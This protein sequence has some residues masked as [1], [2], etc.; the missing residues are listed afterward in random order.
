MVNMSFMEMVQKLQ[1]TYSDIAIKEALAKEVI[2]RAANLLAVGTRILPEIRVN[3]LEGIFQWP[4]EFDAVEEVAEGEVGRLDAIEWSRYGWYLKK[5]RKSFMLTDEA[6]YRGIGD[7]QNRTSVKRAAEAFAKKKDEDIID[8]IV[9]GAGST[10]TIAAGDEWD[11]GNAGVDIVGDVIK[12]RGLI[13]DNSNVTPAELR[14]LKLLVGTGVSSYLLELNLINNVSMSIAQYLQTA[15]G[16]ELLESRDSDLADA[17]Y[18]VVQGE[19]TG[20]H[21]VFARPGAKLSEH[22]RLTG[23]GDR[24]MITQYFASKIEPISESNDNNYRICKI[25]NVAE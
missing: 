10:H 20:R 21:L 1:A 12:A 22:D 2:Y 4:S 25:D 11:S 14:N 18:L 3:V 24:Y 6:V 16:I 9:G 8:S 7:T 13:N 19:D 15:Y 17:A 5:Y 23:V